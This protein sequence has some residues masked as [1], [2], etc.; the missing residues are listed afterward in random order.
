M[1][2]QTLKRGVRVESHIILQTTISATETS[3]VIHNKL[4]SHR[5][6]EE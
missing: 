5:Q 1:K 6:I 2:T 3:H 4:I